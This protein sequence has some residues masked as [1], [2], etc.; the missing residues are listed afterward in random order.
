MRIADS[1]INQLILMGYKKV[2][3]STDNIALLYLPDSSRVII[4][5]LFRVYKGDEITEDDYKQIL[6]QIKT[7]FTEH[8]YQESHLL[9]I[10]FTGN[11][12]KVKH[13]CVDMDVHWLINVDEAR[14]LIYE[15]QSTDYYGIKQI[16][17]DLIDKIYYNKQIL[18]YNSGND[19]GYEKEQDRHTMEDKDE[20][21]ELWKRNNSGD[22]LS[23]NGDGRGKDTIIY[24]TTLMKADNN[25]NN[26]YKTID[27]YIDYYNEEENEQNRSSDSYHGVKL[28]WLS[29]FNTIIILLNI[30]IYLAVYHTHIFG[31]SNQAIAGGALSWYF[32]K[33]EEEY[34]RILTSMFLHSDFSHLIN[35]MLVLFFVGDNLERAA[36]KIRYL[37]FYFGS[38]IIAG[39]SSIGYNMRKDGYNYTFS[40]G[41]SG[42]IFGVVGA[43]VYILIANKG[44]LEDISSRQ[45][46]LFT[47]FSLYGGFFS[48]RIDNAAH[49][50]GF[51]AGLLLAVVLYRKPKKKY[52][53]E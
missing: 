49:I 8:G 50:G 33:E 26:E 12:D 13:L 44:R 48:S 34:Y 10:I 38:G 18:Q 25:P 31:E 27:P 29:L 4:V 19:N 51:M 52:I 21:R 28:G 20:Y 23:N 37:L 6:N 11:P 36:G 14:L 30:L 7:K 17:E 53:L 24:D 45:I 16:I 2:N 43:M 22:Q 32:V 9:S 42:A 3:L 40:V 46:I 15:N 1:L 47:I 5:A 35:N 41:A 39:I